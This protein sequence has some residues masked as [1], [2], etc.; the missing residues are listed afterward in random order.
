METAER[1]RGYEK[2]GGMMVTWNHQI[3]TG[4]G[5]RTWMEVGGLKCLRWHHAW[6]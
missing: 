6:E 3:V 5:W 4:Q 1:G 2:V